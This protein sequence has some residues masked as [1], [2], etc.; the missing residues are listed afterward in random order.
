M[1]LKYIAGNIDISFDSDMAN[2][3]EENSNKENSEE[4]N[5]KILI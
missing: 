3:D 5:L 1:L 2:S 4:E